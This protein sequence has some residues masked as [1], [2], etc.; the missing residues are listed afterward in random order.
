MPSEEFAM[1]APSTT[2]DHTAAKASTRRQFLQCTS[3]A[4]AAAA[5]ASRATVALGAE[6]KKIRIGVAG[7]RMGATLPWHQHPHCVVQAVADLR[8]DNR[9]NLV[10]QFAPKTVYKSF[11]EMVLDKD[12]DAVAVFTDAPLHVQHTELA[13]RHGKHVISAV[14]ACFGTLDEAQWLLDTVKKYGLT[15]MLAETSFYQQATISARKFF[16]EGAFGNL[17]YCESHYDHPGVDDMGMRDGRRTWRYGV[18]PM[19]YPTHCTSH[20]VSVTGERL[21]EVACH[22]WGDEAPCLKDNFYNNPYWAEMAMFKTGRGHGF[23]VRIAWRGAMR[24]C[25]RA[26]WIGDKMSF[27]MGHPNGVGPVVVR[28]GKQ[29]GKDSAGFPVAL[30]GFEQYKQ[31]EW[32]KTDMLPES[33]RHSS[34]HEGSHAFLANEFINALVEQRRPAIDVYE[35]LAYTVPGIVAHQSAL[36][37]GALLKIPQYDPPAGSRPTS[38]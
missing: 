21:V 1:N 8:E 20:L 36:Q 4:L 28:S 23:R 32:F 22:G 37:G 5:L 3:T 11:E 29:M 7:G 26:E 19:H 16:Q 9:N 14:P 27:Y 18:A 13:M 15:Y 6:P 34:G 31:V 33:M 38:A 25:E 2:P 12:V 17:F 30:P 35:G 10:K 24:G